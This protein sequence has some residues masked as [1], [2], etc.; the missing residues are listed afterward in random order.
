MRLIDAVLLNNAIRRAMAGNDPAPVPYVLALRVNARTLEP[1]M[2]SYESARAAIGESED[3]YRELL[4][5]DIDVD[6]K[7]VTPEQLPAQLP[8]ALLSM[9]ED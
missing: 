2:E 3:A 9:V 7:K 1:F 5:Q 8:P 6:L 4:N